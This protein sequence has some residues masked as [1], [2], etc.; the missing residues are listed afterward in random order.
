MRILLIT[1]SSMMVM[2]TKRLTMINN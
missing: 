2:T 1:I